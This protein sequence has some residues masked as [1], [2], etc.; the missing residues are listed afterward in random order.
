V[1]Y[2]AVMPPR[3]R[4]A[5]FGRGTELSPPNAFERLRS[6]PDPDVPMEYGPPT[7]FHKD[8]SKSI[9]SLND[10]SDTPYRT[11][12]NPYRGC[13]HGCVYCYAR[14]YHE[15][16]GFSAG[17]DF[18]SK[19]VVKEGAPR[20]L[21]DAL[22]SSRW[23]PRPI[24][25]SGATD[26]Y[27]PAERRWRLTRGCL[28]VFAETRNPVSI[29]T[30]NF[31]VTRDIDLLRDLTRRKAAVVTLSLT[32]LDEDLARV[33]EPRASRPSHRL[34]AIEALAKAGIPTGIL[35]APV[36]PS[37][38]DHEMPKILQAAVDAGAAFAGYSM[39]R[40]PGAVRPIFE[41][42]LEVQFPDRK[43]KV[44]HKLEAESC[45]GERRAGGGIFSKTVEGLFEAGRRKAGLSTQWPTLSTASFRR[46]S[47]NQLTLSLP[48][49]D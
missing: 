32:T 8:R 15:R 31:L 49:D 21:R 29:I 46:P 33:L 23:K 9:L 7:V 34:A 24:A 28:E 19:I 36:L 26:C 5:R 38:T 42:W 3:P 2:N 18:E 25:L 12:L 30:K 17:L 10:G 4:V 47:G 22:S 11:M 1:S 14:P 48:A 20:L 41:G 43:E 39:L 16:L 35:I 40:L 6:E 13:E 44:L 27:Q 45:V 37:L